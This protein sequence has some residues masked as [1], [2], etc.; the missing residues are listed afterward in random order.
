MGPVS[1]YPARPM[2]AEDSGGPSQ[3][4]R[5]G[6]WRRELRSFL[7]LLALFG[8][9]FAQ[10]TLDI[11]SKNATVFVSRHTTP[12][13]AILFTLLVILGPPAIAWMI[14]VVSGLVLPRS[15]SI[16]HAFL[17]GVAVA[18][19]AAEVLKKQTA[20]TP[21]RL[22]PT[23]IVV[24]IVAAAAIWRF[25]TIRL[26]LRYLA[27]APAAFAVLFLFFSPVT[28]VVFNQGPTATSGVKVGKPTRIVMIV[29]DEFPLESLLD[30]TGKIDATLYPHF[31][32]LA[33]TS[34]WYRNTTTVAPYTE[35]AVP[36][37]VTGNKPESVPPPVAVAYPHSIFTLLGGA[38]D[39]NVHESVERLC[40][41]SICGDTQKTPASGRSGFRGLLDDAWVAWKEFAEPN[42]KSAALDFTVRQSPSDAN[43]LSKGEEFVKSLVPA[44]RARLDY[45]HVLLPH[46]TWHYVATGQDNK[47]PEVRGLSFYLWYNDRTAEAGRLRHLEQVQAADH[48]LGQ[49]IAKLKRLGAWDSS[50][51]VLTADHGVAFTPQ[52]SIRGATPEN[53]DQIMWTPFFV[54]TPQ[55]STPVVDDQVVESIDVFP[56]IADLI[57]TKLPWKTDGQSVLGPKRP[58]GTRP[59]FKWSLNTLK[60]VPG[61]N[62]AEVNGRAGFSRVLQGRASA[63][64]AA[65]DLRLY[66]IGAYGKLVGARAAPYVDRSGSGSPP[67]GTINH[68]GRYDDV[69]PKASDIPWQYLEG[70]IDLKM[71]Q[72]LAVA[73]NGTVAGIGTIAQISNT[74]YKASSFTNDWW[75]SIAPSLVHR[76]KN[77]IELYQVLGT[78]AEPRLVPVRTTR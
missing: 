45:L 20:L 23:A 17:G 26:W 72:T 37:I 74:F 36:A 33:G 7:E 25:D 9:A 39:M 53:Y 32:E 54:K 18:V 77:H 67:H 51:V 75:A 2:T 66:Q 78:P 28:S 48:L 22:I 21:H 41:A 63:S 29:L 6:P 49:I 56:T 11:L 4:A 69:D 61:T 73:V 15:R 46:Q 24:G 62:Y 64:T 19:L 13:E 60:P 12:V 3:R 71:D 76:G 65:P 5:F 14:E 47:G 58:N 57:D 34:T 27:I 35:V 55:Q 8:V 50:L 38:Y 59:L 31:A 52:S 1:T 43:A 10:P 70:T 44:K 42:E 16:V 68:S 30:G 40:P